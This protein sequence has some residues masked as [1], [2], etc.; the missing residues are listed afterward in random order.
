MVLLNIYFEELLGGI[1]FFFD[2]SERV[3]EGI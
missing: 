2:V 1:L 3:E